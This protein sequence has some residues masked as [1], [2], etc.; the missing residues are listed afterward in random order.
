M[1]TE[2]EQTPSFG[3]SIPDVY[4]RL[5]V[6]MIF[7]TYADD[8][9]ARVSALHPHDVLEI[10]AGTGVVTRAMCA[11]LPRDV[12]I[13]A[14]DLQQAMLDQAAQRGTSRPVEWRQADAM[15]LPFD[16]ESFDVVVCQFGAMFFPDRAD[17][18]R[19]VRRVLRPGG[20]F[21]FNV[22]DGVEVNDFARIVSESVAADFPES[23]PVFIRRLPHGYHDPVQIR[24]DLAAAGYPQPP[25]IVTREARSVC[26]S[27]ELAATAYCHGTPMRNEIVSRDPDG[28]D[29]VT[30]RA[31]A[32][33]AREYGTTDIDGRISAKVVTVAH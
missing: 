10:A 25:E 24:A 23:P 1:V 13:T 32:A 26:A 4:E 18:F 2:H 19:E 31:T 33:I 15:V 7:E 9:A 3:G 27:A 6:P 11:R 14:T 16:D 20:S 22:W 12:R 5:L 28:L 30:A 17:A 29:A 21:V 8:I